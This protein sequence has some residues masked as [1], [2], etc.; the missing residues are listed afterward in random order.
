MRV[1]S[2]SRSVPA[3]GTP[4]RARGFTI[5]ELMIT[6]A[7]A[8]ILLV[9][10]VPSFN[11]I[12]NTNRLNAAANSLIGALNTAR[13]AAIQQN[14]TAQFC[15][16]VAATNKTGSTD[17]LGVACNTNTGEVFVFSAGATSATQLTA[18]PP[19]LSVSS[20]QIHGT[21]AAIRYN[22]QGLGYAPGSTTPFDSSTGG[23][24]VDV[25]STALSSNNH[26]Q[27]SMAAG[28]IVSTTTTSNTGSDTCP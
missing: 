17:T 10:A 3:I 6:I 13:M 7:V 25:C 23:V 15:S 27:I 19:E 22:S 5:V 14:A 8:A 12:I 26:I 21:V 24:V 9:I 1:P 28:S 20:I 16:N 4:C 18:P 2:Q 11:K